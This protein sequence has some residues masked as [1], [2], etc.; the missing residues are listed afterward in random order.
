MAVKLEPESESSLGLVEIKFSGLIPEFR[1]SRS[2]VGPMNLCS[3]KF[4]VTVIDAD[5]PRTTP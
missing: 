5:G 4:S 3:N 1:V 2:E